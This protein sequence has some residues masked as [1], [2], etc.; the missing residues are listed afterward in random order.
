MTSRSE[1]RRPHLALRAR[2]HGGEVEFEARDR[3]AIG[4]VVVLF[5]VVAIVAMVVAVVT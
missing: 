1:R 3:Y 2:Y 5:A 4:A